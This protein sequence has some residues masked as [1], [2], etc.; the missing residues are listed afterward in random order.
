MLNLITILNNA[1]IERRPTKYSTS[2]LPD[3]NSL[4]KILLKNVGPKKTVSVEENVKKYRCS[5][6]ALWSRRPSDVAKWWTNQWQP[7]QLSKTISNCIFSKNVVIFL[8]SSISKKDFLCFQVKMKDCL[9]YFSVECLCKY[10][11]ILLI[12]LLKSFCDPN[13]IKDVS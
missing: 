8:F 3:L 1:T 4:T 10:E 11:T 9:K 2:S 13:L 5:C 7:C 12:L 6:K